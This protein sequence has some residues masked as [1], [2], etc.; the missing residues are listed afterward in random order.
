MKKG[1]AGAALQELTSNS[2][3][4]AYT[5]IKSNSLRKHCQNNDWIEHYNIFV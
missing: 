3:I 4:I 5:N 1:V 2:E